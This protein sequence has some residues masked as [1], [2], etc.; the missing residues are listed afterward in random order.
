LF[1]SAHDS[2]GAG[3]TRPFPQQSIM[4]GSSDEHPDP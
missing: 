1:A 2:D 4:K 3:Q